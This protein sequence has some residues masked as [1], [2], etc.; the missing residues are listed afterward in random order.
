M[1]ASVPLLHPGPTTKY[2][3]LYKVARSTNRHTRLPSQSIQTYLPTMELLVRQWT[4]CEQP[5]CR[6]AAAQSICHDHTLGCAVLC[7]VY[8]KGP[9]FWRSFSSRIACHP[10]RSR[11]FH[12]DAISCARQRLDHVSATSASQPRPALSA[13]PQPPAMR[14]T[15]LDTAVCTF[16]H[17][18]VKIA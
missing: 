9:G 3:V 12:F 7:K 8:Q 13:L 5:C 10:H 14:A 2:I 16:R 6:V 11:N 17:V 1:T 18:N 4:V 15:R